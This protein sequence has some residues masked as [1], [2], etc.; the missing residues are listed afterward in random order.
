MILWG[1]EF[2]CAAE[3]LGSNEQRTSYGHPSHARA[4][5]SPK[6]AIFA[7]QTGTDVLFHLAIPAGAPVPD[8]LQLLF[9]VAHNQL[10]IG[11]IL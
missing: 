6:Y 8:H 2:N 5:F 1:S 7:L 4:I 11:T 10:V 9:E 3:D